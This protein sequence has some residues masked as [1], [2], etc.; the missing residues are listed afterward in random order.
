MQFEHLEFLLEEPSAEAA[1]KILLPKILPAATTYALHPFQGKNDLFKN[2]S[3]RLR[4]YRGWLP[5]NWGIIVLFDEDRED[6]KTLKQQAEAIAQGAGFHTKSSPDLIGGFQVITR[7]CVEEL[8]AWFLG[9]VPAICAAYPG[10]SPDLGQRKGYRNPDAVRGG[11]WEALERVLQHAGYHMGGLAKTQAAR[12][13]C[14][15][16]EPNR[17]T[18]HCFGVLRDTLQL[19]TQ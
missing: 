7:L 10:V 4:G 16:M 12:D 8:E 6:Y 18:S 1:L 9:D 13:I 19:I 11:T 14:A 5:E 17:N 15:H 2:L 3:G